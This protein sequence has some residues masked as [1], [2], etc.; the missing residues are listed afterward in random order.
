MYLI[1]FRLAIAS[2]W[3]YLNSFGS[4]QTYYETSM[5]DLAPSTISWIGSLQIWFT[6]VGGIFTGRLLDAGYFVPTF[7]VG[8]VLQVLGLFLISICTKYWQLMLTQGILTGVGG[9]IFFTPALALVATYFE[10]RRGLAM[11]LVTTG[12]S[13]G[14]MIYPIVVR[15]LLPKLGFAWTT[16]VLGFI[17]LGALT[18]CVALMRPRL[19]PRKS[20]PMIDW[21]A[22]RDPV[23]NTFIAGWWLIMWANYY[24]FYYIASYGADVLGLSYSSAS[25]LIIVV[26]GAGL[27]FRVLVPLFSDR[28]GPLNVLLP[29]TS[30][31]AII[32]FCWL[33]VS[34]V[35]G[36]YVW[37][38]FYGAVS[39]SFQCLL[40]TTVASITPRLDKVGTRM[41]IAFFLVAFSSMTGPPVGGA[42]Q[43]ADGGGYTGAQAWAASVTLVGCFLCFVARWYRAGGFDPKFKC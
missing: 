31:W 26:N 34:S 37:T 43:T 10:K 9:G 36:Y 30:I 25:I 32:A 29:V 7:F 41:G 16:R 20:G 23:W 15:Q 12:N 40:P 14:G 8:A 2:T 38:A 27:P 33:A 11:G 24:T 21:S 42:L 6:M 17:N 28:F 39:A 4:F 1:S 35:P 3:G 18:V 13:A 5:P 22:F 19:P